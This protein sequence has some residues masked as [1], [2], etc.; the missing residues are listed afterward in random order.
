MEEGED[1]NK[2]VYTRNYCVAPLLFLFQ[3]AC[4]TQ[5]SS[6]VIQNFPNLVTCHFE[7]FILVTVNSP[8]T[9]KRN[10]QSQTAVYRTKVKSTSYK[11]WKLLG[12]QPFDLRFA[13]P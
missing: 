3:R 6:W 1:V 7:A 10:L 13:L 5:L 8:K 12:C 11:H 4:K 2:I 9:R